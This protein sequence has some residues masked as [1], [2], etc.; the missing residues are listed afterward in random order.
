MHIRGL[1][2][3]SLFSFEFWGKK[4]NKKKTKSVKSEDSNA[5]GRI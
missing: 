2:L 4:K 1:A 5:V 3:S